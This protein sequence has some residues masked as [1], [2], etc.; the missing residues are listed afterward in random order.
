[1]N[2]LQSAGQIVRENV[3]DIDK[4]LIIFKN[5]S[6]TDS[7]LNDLLD[8]ETEQKKVNKIKN[9]ESYYLQEENTLFVTL[10]I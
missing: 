2:I 9:L 1:M 5:I 3:N 8:F 10:T 4:F 6:F 7:S